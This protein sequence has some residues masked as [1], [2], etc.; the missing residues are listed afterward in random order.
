M[1]LERHIVFIES[2]TTGTGRLFARVA[3]EHGLA[4]LLLS[5][6]PARYPYVDEDGLE[7]LSLDT[8][9]LVALLAACE[10]LAQ[11]GTLAGVYSSSEYFIP[12]A[13]TV[14]QH[15]GL[16]GPEPIAVQRCRNKAEQRRVLRA[17]GVPVPNFRPV[18]E[19]EQA[20]AAATELG[21]PVVVKPVEG[22]GS[23]GVRLCET[24]AHVAD[25]VT[26]LLRMTHNERGLP[27]PRLILVEAQVHGPEFSVETFGAQIIGVT[28]KQ[29]GPLPQ[30]I[31]I[32]HMFPADLPADLADALGAVV[33]R[34]L[35]ALGMHW[36]PCHTEL[37]LTTDGPVIIEVNPRLA[38]GF[39]PELVR[40]AVGIDLIDATVRLVAGLPGA[41]IPATRRHAAIR[42]V[43]TP[44]TGTLRDVAGVDAA[45]QVS[46]VDEVLMYRRAGDVVTLRGD[47]RDRIGHVI[48][49]ADSAAA[50]AA[51]TEAAALIEPLVEPPDNV[52]QENECR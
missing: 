34:A 21:Y 14:C 13:A 43:L 15:F 35:D 52:C 26:E 42:F 36:G 30:F 41:L 18:S 6:D 20:L 9:D 29:L 44:A 39:I 16:P 23:V 46:S 8:T 31:E 28:A 27:I 1:M 12:A 48:A 24:P 25:H 32:G 51:A 11:A 37:R 7:Y 17:A 40:R 3:R 19:V 45:R 47:F 10:P 5:A 33:L 50:Q 49:V 22:S 4:P 38:G 2:N